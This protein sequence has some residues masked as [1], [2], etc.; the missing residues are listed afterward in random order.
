MVIHELTSA[1][2][3]EFL[4]RQTLAHL[5]CARSNQPYITPISYYYDAVGDCLYSFATLGQKIE[6]MRENPKVCVEVDEILDRFN[7]TSV[8]VVGHYHE[9][10]D[11]PGEVAALVRA[12]ELFEQQQAWWLPGAGQLTS[13]REHASPV[14]YRIVIARAS[15]RRA[16]RATT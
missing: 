2:C 4:A 7:W 1:Q 15:G 9:L 5:A 13:G 3:R 16:G 14:I 8:I 6:W 10:L 11:A 12:R